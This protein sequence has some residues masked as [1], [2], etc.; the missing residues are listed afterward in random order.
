MR[1]CLPWP[2]TPAAFSPSAANSSPASSRRNEEISLRREDAVR[3]SSSSGWVGEGHR[4]NTRSRRTESWEIRSD[5]SY[6]EYGDSLSRQRHREPHFLFETSSPSRF[7]SCRC[8][9]SENCSGVG[10]TGRRRLSLEGGGTSNFRA[11][12]GS[13]IVDGGGSDGVGAVSTSGSLGMTG[14]GDSIRTRSAC[15]CLHTASADSPIPCSVPSSRPIAV[16]MSSSSS[17]QSSPSG[18]S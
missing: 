11:L 2:K 3:S 1:T 18:L 6:V 5:L 17:N 4:W 10:G 12:A 13:G 7:A 9:N 14:L 8:Q 15:S 16:R